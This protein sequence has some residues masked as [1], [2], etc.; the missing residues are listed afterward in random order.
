MSDER[1]ETCNKCGAPVVWCTCK[2]LKTGTQLAEESLEKIR[3]AIEPVIIKCCFIPDELQGKP[4]QST[5]CEN[6]CNWEVRNA[7]VRDPH[8]N[9]TYSCDEHLAKMLTANNMVH[10]IGKVEGTGN[11]EGN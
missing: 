9:D 5:W 3:T 11:D 4:E 6:P 7:D 1:P 10:F 2:E 8:E